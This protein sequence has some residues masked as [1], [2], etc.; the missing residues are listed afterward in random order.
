MS[1]MQY[2]HSKKYLSTLLE[3]M[4]ININQTVTSLLQL[5][6]SRHYATASKDSTPENSLLV[7]III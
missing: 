7:Q 3:M 5:E 6:T 4:I 1:S 2:L